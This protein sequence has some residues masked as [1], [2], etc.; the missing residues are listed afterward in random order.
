M[1]NN[2]IGLIAKVGLSASFGSALAMKFLQGFWWQ[3]VLSFGASMVI[4]CLGGGAAME[5]FGI[6]P[7][8]YMHMLMTASAAV[9]GLSIVNNAM[10]QIPQI[11][12]GLRHRIFGRED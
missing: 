11:I 6:T 3:R 5:H 10:Q 1:D 8:S 4:G 12:A 7:G 9:F 2:D